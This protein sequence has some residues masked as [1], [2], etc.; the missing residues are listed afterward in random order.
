MNT[1][2][3]YKANFLIVLSV[4][5]I[6]ITTI[7]HGVEFDGKRDMKFGYVKVYKEIIWR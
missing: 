5:N 6:H 4:L 1:K 3:S 2:V 7:Q